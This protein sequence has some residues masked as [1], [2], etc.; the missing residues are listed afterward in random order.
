MS[1]EA[2]KGSSPRPFS[3]THDEYANRWEMIFKQKEVEEVKKD[4][5]FTRE[6]RY[7]V[8]KHSDM[9]VLTGEE[10]ESLNILLDKIAQGRQNKG[11]KDLNCVVVEDDWPEYEAVWAMIENRVRNV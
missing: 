7:T 11:K 10:E 3:I 4:V 5:D 9:D 6:S 8:I 2:G 1:R